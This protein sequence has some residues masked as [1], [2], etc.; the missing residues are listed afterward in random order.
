M[1]A[2][3][4]PLGTQMGCWRCCVVIRRAWHPL[5]SQKRGNI[6]WGISRDEMLMI[7]STWKYICLPARAPI[8]HTALGLKQGKNQSENPFWSKPWGRFSVVPFLTGRIR[9]G[10]AIC[11]TSCCWRH[12]TG[13]SPAFTPS[14]VSADGSREG[15]VG[16]LVGLQ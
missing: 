15:S 11:M 1:M 6:S 9:R 7:D 12:S 16:F 4:P 5:C 2:P 10:C 3:K 13:V 14:S 8:L